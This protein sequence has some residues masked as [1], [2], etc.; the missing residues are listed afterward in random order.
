MSPRVLGH[1]LPGVR[2]VYDRHRYL[3][4]KHAALEHLAGLIERIIAPTAGHRTQAAGRSGA[5]GRP[6]T[7][8]FPQPRVPMAQITALDA[9]S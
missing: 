1:A 9:H 3:A 6:V 7:E 4:E 5:D 2:G 8:S